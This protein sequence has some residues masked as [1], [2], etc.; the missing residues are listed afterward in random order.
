MMTLPDIPRLYTALCE[1]GACMLLIHSIG[2]LRWRQKDMLKAIGCLAVQ[3]FLQYIAGLLPLIYWVPGMFVNVLWM[4]VTLGLFVKTN[5]NN[6]IFMSV[7]A[8]VSAELCAAI[9]WQAY[10]VLLIQLAVT[11][12]WLKWSVLIL[13]S[14]IVLGSIWL[15]ETRLEDV[16]FRQHTTRKDALLAIAT[17]VIIFAV[18]NSGF[19]LNNTA[20]RLADGM[21]IFIVRT[22]VNISGLLV[23]Y[24][25]EHQKYEAYLRQEVS[26]LSHLFHLQSEQYKAYAQSSDMISRKVHD[27]K[28][29]LNALRLEEDRVKKEQYMDDIEQDIL[30]FESKIETGHPAL[31]TVLTKVNQQCAA[32]GIQFTCLAQGE[33]LA[34]METLDLFALF[35][36]ALDNAIEAVEKIPLDKERLINFKLTQRGA[37]VIIR[38]ANYVYETLPFKMGELPQ[39][40]KKNKQQHGYG[41]KSMQQ[42]VEKY[43]GTL[44]LTQDE[45]WVNLNILFPKQVTK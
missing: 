2:Q 29:H 30:A 34:F 10:T 33:L 40:S 1:W 5:L 11:Q 43:Q 25:Q 42:I 31:D 45:H 18:S 22:L 15:I 39:T 27:L 4:F 9:G 20:F 37:F 35:G 41:L 36:N 21:S 38:I 28:H 26:A 17:G 19:L 44:T 23:L 14:A 24:A 16:T 7:K 13:F 6:R 3:L 12:L 32:Q 8:F